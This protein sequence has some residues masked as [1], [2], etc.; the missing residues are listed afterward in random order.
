MNVS[1]YRCQCY[2]CGR[3]AVAV[4]LRDRRHVGYCADHVQLRPLRPGERWIY[5]P[6]DEAGEGVK[7]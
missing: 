5:P 2:G 7:I 6:P 4:K 3:P 1:D